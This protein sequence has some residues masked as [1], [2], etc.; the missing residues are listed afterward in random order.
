MTKDEGKVSEQV[1]DFIRKADI[2]EFP[3]AVVRQGK[4][5]LVDGIGVMLAGSTAH[6]S[7][8]LRKHIR[9]FSGPPDATVLGHERL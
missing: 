8:I 6:C 9:A 5:C 2:R 7:A 4:R 3:D 1:V